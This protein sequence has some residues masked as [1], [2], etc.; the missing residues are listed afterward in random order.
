MQA[1]WQVAVENMRCMFYNPCFANKEPCKNKPADDFNQMLVIMC[2][3][4]QDLSFLAGLPML[5]NPGNV[6]E[7]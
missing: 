7:D 6:G 2:I 5:N 1:T 4:L 3:K